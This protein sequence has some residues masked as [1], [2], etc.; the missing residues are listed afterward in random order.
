[1]LSRMHPNA[2]LPVCARP[3]SYKRKIAVRHLRAAHLSD[4]SRALIAGLIAPLPIIA[5]KTV[6]HGFSRPIVRVPPAEAI[7]GCGEPVNRRGGAAGR[8]HDCDHRFGMWRAW[9]VGTSVPRIPS[10]RQQAHRQQ[11]PNAGDSLGR[12]GWQFQPSLSVRLRRLKISLANLA[13]HRGFPPRRRTSASSIAGE[14]RKSKK[15]QTQPLRRIEEPLRGLAV[16]EPHVASRRAATTTATTGSLTVSHRPN[17]REESRAVFLP[18]RF[19][20]ATRNTLT[21]NLSQSPWPQRIDEPRSA[22]CCHQ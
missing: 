14:P 16:C 11:D 15:G 12:R 17:A 13:K 22:A 2:H 9:P 4:W 1:M 7:A 8:W 6:V 10:E 21:G 19:S 3:K 5:V 18:A 20:R